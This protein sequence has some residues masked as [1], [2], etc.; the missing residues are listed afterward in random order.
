MFK[1][2]RKSVLL[3]STLQP[4]PFWAGSENFWFD[5]VAD[6]RR[7]SFFQ[8][9]V[10]LAD[11]QVTRAKAEALAAAGAG[12]S[13]YKHFNVN[14]ARRNIYR[15]SDRIRRRSERTLPWYDVIKNGRWDLVWFSVDGLN[16]LL[17]LEYAAGI[18]REQGIPYW[19]QLQH[20]YEDFF[21]TTARDIDVVSL[22]AV[23]ARRF[24][25]IADRNR[26]SLERAIGKR[27]DNAFFSVN[28]LPP[29][30]IAEAGRV[31]KESPPNSNGT[32]HFFNLG[33]FSP[34]DKGQH[35][36]LE[37][38]ADGEWK[39][40]AWELSFIGIDDFGR[41][42]LERL[43]DFFGIEKSKIRIV[44]HTKDVFAEI[45]RHD[46]LLMPSL[47]EGTPFAMIESMACGRPAIGT[48]VGGIPELIRDGETG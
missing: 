14:F 47:A 34:K 46:V 42:Y 2:E 38:L 16:S 30:K 26:R 48:P 31:S 32:A 43:I 29:A 44:P 11:S 27:L 12:V 6:E 7:N 15:L 36:L 45:A 18:C 41:K 24:I 5:F 35:L 17:D 25:F 37:A 39:E 8:F 20:G 4:Y 3:F 33:R 10:S 13:F 21:L 28:A 9:H 19:L 1:K 40:R 22:V 23:E